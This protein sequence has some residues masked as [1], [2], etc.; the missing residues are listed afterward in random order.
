MIRG[1]PMAARR[2]RWSLA[3]GSGR[4][5]QDV[6]GNAAQVVVSRGP[7]HARLCALSDRRRHDAPP[8]VR[9]AWRSAVTQLAIVADDLTGAAD[10][11]ACFANAGFATVIPL[12]DTAIPDADVVVLST[13]SRDMGASDAARAVTAAV[14]RL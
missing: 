10:T 5:T 1:A 14:A 11:G 9:Y 4:T 13:E 6:P 7:A 2:D 8:P 3:V 12:S